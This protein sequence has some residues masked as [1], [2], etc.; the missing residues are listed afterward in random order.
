M[1]PSPSV[2]SPVRRGS[3]LASVPLRICQ[4]HKS[5]NKRTQTSKID[6][7]V[8]EPWVMFKVNWIRAHVQSVWIKHE[9]AWKWEVSD[10][11]GTWPD[12]RCGNICRDKQSHKGLWKII[13]KKT[14][15]GHTSS[16][17]TS[18]S[19]QPAVCHHTCTFA[20][21]WQEHALTKIAET[22]VLHF[23]NNKDGRTVEKN[24]CKNT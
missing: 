2:T 13:K 19:V 1:L 11:W 16:F 8:T 18:C 21:C 17:T 10:C 22:N 23:S 9:Y 7:L 15:A 4:H 20:V 24:T 3:L 12:E 6:Q 14:T 5:E